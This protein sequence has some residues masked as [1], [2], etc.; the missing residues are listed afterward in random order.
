MVGFLGKALNRSSIE[1]KYKVLTTTSNDIPTCYHFSR[2][3]NLII[4]K[5]LEGEGYFAF[6]S[7]Q[8]FE[9]FKS[10]KNKNELDPSGVGVPLLHII[11]RKDGLFD[12]KVT[13]TIGF[14][15]GMKKM[16]FI[17][18]IYEMKS[19]NEPP[20][21]NKFEII[22]ESETHT[23]YKTPFCQ[24]TCDQLGFTKEYQFEYLHTVNIDPIGMKRDLRTENYSSNITGQK[25]KWNRKL[26]M[27]SLFSEDSEYE[28]LLLEDINNRPIPSNPKPKIAYYTKDFAD[29]FYGFIKRSADLF[30]GEQ[31]AADS[32]GIVGV[33]MLTVAITCEALVLHYV[34]HHRKL[35]SRRRARRRN[36][37]RQ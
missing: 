21:Y 22:I 35:E 17:I 28:L 15:L 18:Y 20:P 37:H 27:L 16:S 31:S 3:R 34:E 23:L 26:T 6:S 14:C 25:L 9:K 13:S 33:P 1:G 12:S 30:V 24:V 36:M 32:L 19:K 5:V 11:S 10:S 4:A 8:S 2:R 7:I 29:S